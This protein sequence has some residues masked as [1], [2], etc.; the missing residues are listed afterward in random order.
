MGRIHPKGTTHIEF[1]PSKYEAAFSNGTFGQHMEK[2]Y[3]EFLGND[4]TANQCK[5]GVFPVGEVK[6][7]N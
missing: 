6:T 4:G 7:V 2:H 5:C 3:G 1:R